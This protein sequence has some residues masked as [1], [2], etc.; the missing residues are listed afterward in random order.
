MK[1]LTPGL[2]LAAL[3]GPAAAYTVP[4]IE[5]V[6]AVRV[7]Q[8]GVTVRMASNGC[9]RKSDLTVAVAKTT[10]RPL[11]L[12][13]RQHPDLC[14]AASRAVEIAWTFQDLGLAADEP[15]NLANPLTAEPGTPSP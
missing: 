7:D 11:L 2:L 14:Q 5:P 15:F 8:A 10:A 3:A 6:Y 12:I 1:L 9:T 4:P 13:A